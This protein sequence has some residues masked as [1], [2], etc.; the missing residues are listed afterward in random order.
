MRTEDLAVDR[1]PHPGV[2]HDAN[3]SGSPVAFVTALELTCPCIKDVLGCVRAL[4]VD[5]GV[6]VVAHMLIEEDIGSLPLSLLF[7]SEIR[8]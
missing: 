6:G 1:P 5:E 4:G 3:E 8:H 7:L 2:P